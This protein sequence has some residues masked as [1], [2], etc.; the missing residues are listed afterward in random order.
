M[1]VLILVSFFIMLF[2]NF[3]VAIA[4]GAASVLG[5]VVNGDLSGIVMAQKIYTATD[6][7]SLMAIPFFMLAGQLM[8]ATGI[9]D[10]IV[11]FAKNLVGH[12]RGGLAHTTIVSGMLMAGISGSAYADASAIGAIMLP[13]MNKSGFSRGF[14]VSVVSAAAGLGPII[15]P[16]IVM[17]I[18]AGIASMS[19]GDLFLAGYA[20]GIILG[21][22]YMVISFIYATRHQLASTRFAGLKA[23]WKSFIKSVWA[24]LMPLIIIGGI[25]SGVFTSTEAGVVAVVYGLI[26]GFIAKKFTFSKSTFIK[27]KDCLLRAVLSSASPMLIIAIAGLMGYML[28]RENLSNLIISGITALTASPIVFYFILVATLLILGMFIDSSAT[29]LML[30]PVLLPMIPVLGLDSL[31]FAMIFLLS[32]LTAGLMPPVGMLLFIVS[33]IDNTPLRECIKPIIPFITI[34]LLCI[35]MIIFFPQIVLTIPGLFS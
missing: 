7:F 24:I 12:I 13:T 31:H 1:L 27:I 3:P 5:L 2:L 30:L 18:Y 6:S 10:S 17:I 4:M 9:T 25:L 33:G 23:I 14:S 21:L 34:M 32:L 19:V 35:V 8:E 29:L 22:G 28:A 20:P 16:S 26:Y 11:S 15:P